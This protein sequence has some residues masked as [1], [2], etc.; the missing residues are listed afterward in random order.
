M[1]RYSRAAGRAMGA[2]AGGVQ[3]P[4]L[5]TA[6]RTA[7]IADG[8]LEFVVGYSAIGGT[9][10]ISGPGV[11]WVDQ[12]KV[13]CDIIGMG[14]AWMFLVGSGKVGGEDRIEA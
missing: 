5:Q 10:V 8:E 13:D 6:G 12:G 1:G 4:A 2:T 11:F 9:D 7:G 14:T 3:A